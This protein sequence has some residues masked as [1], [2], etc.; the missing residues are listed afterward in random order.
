MTSF[1]LFVTLVG[2]I[3]A[4]RVMPVE[5]CRA[6]EFGIV[7]QPPLKESA[8]PNLPLV[9]RATPA[10]K[11]PV[12]VPAASVTDEPVASL[13]PYAATRPVCALAE[14][15]AAA[16]IAA[17]DRAPIVGRKRRDPNRADRPGV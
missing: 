13:K 8:P 1:H 11:V 17:I 15:G 7:T 12:F 10:P 9:V 16:V 5:S 6:A 2:L 4:S 14:C 3:Q